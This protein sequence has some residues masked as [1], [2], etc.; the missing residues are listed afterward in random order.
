MKTTR[1]LRVIAG[2]L[3]CSM[4]LTAQ[5]PVPAKKGNLATAK[6]AKV[7]LF[8]HYVWGQTKGKPDLYTPMDIKGKKPK[9][10]NELADGFDAKKLADFA[11]AMGAEYVVFTAFHAGM[12]VLYPS[13]VMGEMLP[14]KASRRDVLKDLQD[15]LDAK[16]I[17]LMLYWHPT[18]AH[19]LSQSDKDVILAKYKTWGPFILALMKETSARY[20]SRVAGYWFDAPAGKDSQ[21]CVP[22]FQS[23][24]LKDTPDVAIWANRKRQLIPGLSNVTTT[25]CS[26]RPNKDL[27]TDNWPTDPSQMC[28]LAGKGWWAKP[29][30]TAVIDAR[31]MFRYTV[32][33][34]ATKGQTNGGVCWSDGPYGDNTW[35]T[36]TAEAYGE[37]GKMLRARKEAIYGTKPST[38]YVT[39]PD[40]LQNDIWGVATDSADGKTVFLHVLNP[41]TD[42]ALKIAK[43]ADNRSFAK[44]S[45]LDGTPV[46]LKATDSGYELTLPSGAK[47]DKDDT[48][49]RLQ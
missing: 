21:S 14:E 6:E 18:D 22:Q 49:I 32:R 40:T 20:G 37:M 2:L 48:V 33:I 15:A 34:A 16:G 9:D 36:G 46:A 5:E 42:S 1:I 29:N 43:P 25:E 24:I 38:C 4:S 12:N 45:L 27:N 23:I 11:E 10:I 17:K 44:A 31:G 13:Q 28:V 41:P 3:I 30:A 8:V 7:G 19:D 39:L 47:W 35:P 26:P